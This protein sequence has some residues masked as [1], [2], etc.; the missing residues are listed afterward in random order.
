MNI[1]SQNSGH[2]SPLPVM[3]GVP[4]DD[5]VALVKTDSNLEAG[6]IPNTNR[7]LRNHRDFLSTELRTDDLDSIQNY[8]W[9]AGL[10][11]FKTRPLHRQ[12]VV[13]RE[14]VVCE[15][16]GL[17]LVSF[18]SAIFIKPIPHALLHHK[19]FR[20]YIADVPDLEPWASGF[21][22]SYLSLIVH[23]SDF[24]VAKQLYL[25]PQSVT[26]GDWLKFSTQLIT[27]LSNSDGTKKTFHNRYSFGELRLS[28][29]NLIM[30]FIRFRVARGYIWLDT[31]YSKYFSRYFALVILLFAAYFSLALSAFQVISGVA[32]TL[33]TPQIISVVAYWF[34]LVTLLVLTTTVVLPFVWLSVLLIIQYYY[35]KTAKPGVYERRKSP[36][37]KTDD[38]FLKHQ[39]QILWCCSLTPG[40]SL[41]VPVVR[42]FKQCIIF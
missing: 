34:A 15:Q 12:R 32:S 37:F 1:L 36:S 26:W 17:H 21:L 14:I 33:H 24:I 38:L 40:W 19:F 7:P 8:F 29:L 27:A 13:Q 9:L 30:Q 2:F 20:D 16:I 28:R 31:Q 6:I 4:F 18:R 23:E 22:S 35:I 39:L 11:A 10:P 41:R 25:L 3:L 42:K 5:E